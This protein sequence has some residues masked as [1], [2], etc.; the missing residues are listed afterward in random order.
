M[1]AHCFKSPSHRTFVEPVEVKG[2]SELV[3]DEHLRPFELK[4]PTEVEVA[5][6]SVEK[7]CAVCRTPATV[8]LV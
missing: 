6:R 8:T 3:M 5:R 1:T 7:V 4:P 2:K